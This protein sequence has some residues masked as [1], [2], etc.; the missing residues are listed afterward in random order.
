M[1][2]IKYDMQGSKVY[3]AEDH[4]TVKGAFKKFKTIEGVENWVN[5]I[6]DSK[7]WKKFKIPFFV[8]NPKR[9]KNLHPRYDRI[10]VHDSKKQDAE[11]FHGRIWMPKWSRSRLFILHEI[12][13]AIQTE[14]PWHDRQFCA[15]YLSLIKK[16]IGKRAWKQMK[17]NFDVFKVEY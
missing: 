17:D 12:A 6:T 7:W 11:G 9:I 15:I 14:K 2:K 8:S 1:K 3:A 5:K 13:H 4:L 16:W 10:K